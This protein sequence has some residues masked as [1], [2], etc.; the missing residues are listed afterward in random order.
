MT[1]ARNATQQGTHSV[2]GEHDALD[3]CAIVTTSG[4]GGWGGIAGARVGPYTLLPELCT[5]MSCVN[6]SHYGSLDTLQV[7]I[8]KFS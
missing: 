8:G 3:D 5:L 4:G 1:C 2:I 6:F 7:V